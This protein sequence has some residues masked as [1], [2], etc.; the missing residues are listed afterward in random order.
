[1]FDTL[2]NRKKGSFVVVQE[3]SLS[4]LLQHE[5]ALALGK[6]VITVGA[7]FGASQVA[8][9]FYPVPMT[10]QTLL[11]FIIGLTYTPREILSS[12]GGWLLL[13]ALGAPVFSSFSG[14]LT[15]LIGPKGGY[16]LGFLLAP[17]VMAFLRDQIPLEEVR[18]RLVWV[19]LGS[20]IV[21]G[22]G[23]LVLAS[24][25]GFEQAV[26]LGLYPFVIGDLL[27]MGIAVAVSASVS[28]PKTK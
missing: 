13:G 26:S 10:L 11:I 17:L 23:L 22:S 8:I 15:V 20:C 28:T 2:G 24:F 16:F 1:M 5:A 25:V 18:G 21:F 12:V 19:A 14:G 3:S 4:R 9:P 27:K 7:L 6:I